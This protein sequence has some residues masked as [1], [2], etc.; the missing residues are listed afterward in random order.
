MSF[1]RWMEKEVLV[2]IYKRILLSHKR[3]K[4]ETVLVR[5]ITID[6]IIQS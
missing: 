5:W 1:D 6:P 3:K 2:H 4:F